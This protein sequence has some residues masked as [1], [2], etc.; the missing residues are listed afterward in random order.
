MLKQFDNNN[1]I[2]LFMSN[3]V[4]LHVAEFIVISVGL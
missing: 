4:L 3:D 1:R 2:I